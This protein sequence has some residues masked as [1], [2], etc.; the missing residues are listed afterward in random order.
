M[1]NAKKWAAFLCLLPC[2]DAQYSAFSVYL[3]ATAVANK[4]KA[5]FYAADLPSL[6]N[7]RWD[8]YLFVVCPYSVFSYPSNSV[9]LPPTHLKS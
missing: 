6:E 8:P 4:T 9:C 5:K 3:V 2:D 7:V 1:Q